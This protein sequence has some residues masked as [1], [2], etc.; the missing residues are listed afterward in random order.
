MLRLITL[1]LLLPILLSAQPLI[2]PFDFVIAAGDS[3]V[4]S[5]LP[6]VEG[7][8]AGAHGFLET[9]SEGHLV[10]ADG[11]PVRFSGVAMQ[12]SACFPDSTGAIRTAA[13]LAKMGVNLVHFNYFDSHNSNSAST[14]LPGRHSDSLAPEQMKR[15]DW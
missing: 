3:V 15:L 14:L 13:H 12:G 11:T 7:G 4:S 5:W 8:I 6:R 2:D 10:F 9:S 1:L